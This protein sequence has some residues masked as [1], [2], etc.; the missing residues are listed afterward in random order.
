MTYHIVTTHDDYRNYWFTRIYSG[1]HQIGFIVTNDKGVSGDLVLSSHQACVWD[2]IEMLDSDN[3][4]Y[5]HYTAYCDLM[6][7]S[8]ICSV[9]ENHIGNIT[10]KRQNFAKNMANRIMANIE[11]RNSL[12]RLEYIMEEYPAQVFIARIDPYARTTERYN[13]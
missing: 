2:Y 3:I 11:K 1:K 5:S 9:I 10:Q 7:N 6:I 8:E 12:S 13:Y 4:D